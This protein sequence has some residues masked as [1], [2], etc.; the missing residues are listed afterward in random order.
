MRKAVLFAAAVLL[1]VAAI[2]AADWP[3]WQGP[4]R[5]RVSL[6]TGLLKQWPAAGPPV[7]WTATGVGS[8]YG[9]MAIA[10]DRVFVQGVRGRNSAV[11]ALNRRWKGS[12]S[13]ALGASQADDRGRTA[14]TP[15]ATAIAFTVLTENGDLA[16]LKNRW[17]SV[18]QR[19]HPS[20]LS[21]AAT[22]VADRESPLVDG[23]HVDCVAGGPGAA[24]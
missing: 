21:R 10:G 1:S 18:W 3:Q 24:S 9:S 17:H 15:T 8:G 4:N 16:C 7:V 12:L 23:A 11:I 14:R 19:N 2:H 5:T 6:E 13:K 22:A 20:R